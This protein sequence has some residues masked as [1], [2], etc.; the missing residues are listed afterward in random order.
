MFCLF[1]ILVYWSWLNIVKP[2]IPVGG[3]IL[4]HKF[5]NNSSC[6]NNILSLAV[7]CPLLLGCGWVSRAGTQRLDFVPARPLCWPHGTSLLRELFINLSST[8]AHLIH[9]HT[10]TQCTYSLVCAA[11]H[12]H[13][14]VHIPFR[15][16]WQLDNLFSASD[17]CFFCTRSCICLVMNNFQL[18]RSGTKLIWEFVIA[19]NIKLFV[20]IAHENPGQKLHQRSNRW[21][22]DPLTLLL[23][24]A[25]PQCTS[26]CT[27]TQS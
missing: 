3:F 22:L 18:I 6:V 5:E 19:I 10:H 25:V 17:K 9:S 4:I 1:N 15:E 7:P 27:D 14:D 24:L 26:L 2:E 21:N 11:T 8:L 16:T 23:E 13:T 20:L 12:T